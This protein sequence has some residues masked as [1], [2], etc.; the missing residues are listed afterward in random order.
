MQ[1]KWDDSGCYKWNES[2]IK[3]NSQVKEPQQLSKLNYPTIHLPNNVKLSPVDYA[4]H[5]G[6]NF[7][8]NLSFAQLYTS[9]LFQNHPSTIFVNS[10]FVIL[11]IKLLPALLLLLSFT[12]KLTIVTLYYLVCLQI[13][14][15]VFN[16]SWTL[17][18]VLLPKL[19]NVITLLLF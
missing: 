19:I 12:L 14:R 1:M 9:L 2:E 7:D 13:K 10:V 18:L 3:Y 5:F 15:I 17:L 16:L 4:R 6:V 8:T 11:L